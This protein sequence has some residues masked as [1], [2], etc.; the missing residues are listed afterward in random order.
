MLAVITPT[1]PSRSELLVECLE[2][3]RNQT[4]KPDFHLVGRDYVGN[5]SLN[6]GNMTPLR[7]ALADVAIK[8]GCNWLSFYDD[9]DLLEPNHFELLMAESE[10]KDIVYS[11]T[12]NEDGPRKD[13]NVPFDP[14]LS[15]TRNYL[16]SNFIIRSQVF[17]KLDGFKPIKHEEWDFWQRAIKSGARIHCIE[18]ATWEYR[19]SDEKRYG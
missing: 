1:I 17:K 4:L 11:W 6:R 5:E 16:C 15:K 8:F 3:V 19:W 13:N 12:T 9:D 7:N 2:S 10:N 14:G 18:K